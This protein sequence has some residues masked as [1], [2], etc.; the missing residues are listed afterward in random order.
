[1]EITW[2][3]IYA[4]LVVFGAGVIRGYSGFGFALISVIMLS[5][6]YPSTLITPLILYLDV[7]ASTWLFYKVRK[8]VDWKGL[9][10]LFIGAIITLPIGSLVLTSVPVNS[11]RI[12]I[13]L[14]ILLLCTGLLRKRQVTRATSTVA[15]FGVGMLSGFLTGV[16]A[17]GGPPVIL[18]YLSSNRSVSISRASMIAFFLVVDCSALIS[19]LWYGLLDSQTLILSAKMLIPLCVGI[20]IGNYLFEKFSNEEKFRRQTLILLMVIAL[21]SLVNSAK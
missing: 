15:T 6:V 2:E 7:I 3:Y 20:L 18:F 14:T 1:M 13:A 21:I 17:I 9:K 4:L 5:F 16:A 8:L 19:C 11:L 12:F 10:I